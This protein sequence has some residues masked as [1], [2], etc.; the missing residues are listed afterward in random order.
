L[1]EGWQHV[2]TG[3]PSDENWLPTTEKVKCL[4]PKKRGDFHGEMEER[5][6]NLEP[7]PNARRNRVK[8]PD[9]H[10]VANPSTGNSALIYDV[11]GM[12]GDASKAYYNAK[13]HG[14]I[15]SSALSKLD[16]RATNVRMHFN[17]R[18]EHAG[19]LM[20]SPGMASS[21]GNR[22]NVGTPGDWDKHDP[23]WEALDHELGHTHST[24]NPEA[25]HKFLGMLIDHH[26][27]NNPKDQVNKQ[28]LMNKYGTPGPYN[29]YSGS[30]IHPEFLN[31]DDDTLNKIN[32]STATSD[33]GAT[34][35][36]E[37]YAEHHAD[38]LHGSKHPLTKRLGKELGWG[39]PI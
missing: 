25:L 36:T 31:R 21:L 7:S 4:F 15:I 2:T 9:M 19:N 8:R 38:Y 10:L 5:D 20:W 24:R 26:N 3:Q 27:Q 1:P 28:K 13:D 33:Y 29:E 34:V 37:N 16:S 23:G 35:L 22:I 11:S 32:G 6:T 30:N 14:T 17:R 18:L 12:N 39:K